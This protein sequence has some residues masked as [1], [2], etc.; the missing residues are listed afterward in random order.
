EGVLLPPALRDTLM[1]NP[2]VR[3]AHFS[4]DAG[5]V[6]LLVNGEVSSMTGLVFPTVSDWSNVSAG[7]YDFG[8][9]PTGGASVLDA[10]VDLA[11]GDHV[12]V[13]V[14]GSAD[15]L[16]ATALYEDYSPLGEDEARLGVF[17]G[18]EGST[19]YNVV[20]S[21][22]TVVIELGYPGT[23][24]GNDG[25]YAVDLAAGTYD[26]EFVVT[27]NPSSVV[28]DAGEITLEAGTNTLV[29]VVGTT[30]A[31]SQVT[32]VSPVA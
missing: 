6:D 32:T 12:T 20:V 22:D 15:S 3:V 14:T 11:L 2:R 10:T 31:P 5:T 9:A 21:G 18:V 26:L 16:A 19:S 28:L 8:V 7:S 24:G 17:N 4:P 13:A 1:A 23:L 27:G 30:D 29:A 25:Y